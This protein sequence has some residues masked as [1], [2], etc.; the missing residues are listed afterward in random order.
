MTTDEW[1]S[2]TFQFNIFVKVISIFFL[3]SYWSFLFASLFVS[4]VAFSIFFLP[5][6]VCLFVCLFLSLSLSFFLS[7][8]PSFFLSYSLS[9]FLSFFLLSFFFP[10]FFLF[11]F[12]LSY[13]LSFFHFFVHLFLFFIPLLF[14]LH[15]FQLLHHFRLP[16]A[17][18]WLLVF[19]FIPYRIFPLPL[20]L[21]IHLSCFLFASLSSSLL[22]FICFSYNVPRLQSSI[23]A[24]LLRDLSFLFSIF[25]SSSLFT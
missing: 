16:P 15:I 22:T 12:L 1:T 3:L 2:F 17:I 24:F 11:S 9:F 6:L 4:L 14:V 23:F 8:F 7:F 20:P 10:S 18:A 5:L 25:L 13:S 21:V 19:L